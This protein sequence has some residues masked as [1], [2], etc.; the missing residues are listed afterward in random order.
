VTAVVTAVVLAFIAVVMAVITGIALLVG[1][2][3]ESVG[4]VVASVFRVVVSTLVV[5]LVLATVGQLFVDQLRSTMLAGS[6]RLGVL[7]GAIAVGSTLALLMLVGNV[8][9]VYDLYP[10]AV[11]QWAQT[12]VRS[13][14]PRFD[15]TVTLAVVALCAFGVLRNLG[16]MR[17]SPDRAMLGRSLIYTIMGVIAAGAIAAVEKGTGRN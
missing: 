4:P 8:Y 14:D 9:G 7:M 10:D 11:A 5:A 16:R 13:N 2:V 1:L 17:P 3:P 15:A 12:S 6:D